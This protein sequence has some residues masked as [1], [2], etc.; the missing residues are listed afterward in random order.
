M[1]NAIRLIALACIH[2]G[3]AVEP[4]PVTVTEDAMPDAAAEASEAAVDAAQRHFVCEVHA[5][6][7]P[8]FVECTT[9]ADGGP[10]YVDG[11][12][13]DCRKYFEGAGQGC[14]PPMA[15]SATIDGDVVQGT[16]VQAP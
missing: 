15:C 8:M 13:V 2:C 14:V 16:C 4:V 3:G 11:E 9:L 6:V 5:A 1:K 10:S 7:D 12:D